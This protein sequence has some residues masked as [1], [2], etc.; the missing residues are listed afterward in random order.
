MAKDMWAR[1][2]WLDEEY[3]RERRTVD[4]FLRLLYGVL[5]VVPLIFVV[6]MTA[7][8]WFSTDDWAPIPLALGGSLLIVSVMLFGLFRS[9]GDPGLG[10]FGSQIKELRRFR[11]RHAEKEREIVLNE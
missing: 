5:I 11:E 1:M 3:R 2:G 10:S 8:I 6:G 7:V 9:E 4:D